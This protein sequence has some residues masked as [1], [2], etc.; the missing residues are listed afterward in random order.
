MPVT[1]TLLDQTHNTIGW[2]RF[3]MEGFHEPQGSQQAFLRG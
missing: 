2:K 1:S 3:M